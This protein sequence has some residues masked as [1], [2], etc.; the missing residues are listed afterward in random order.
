VHS[1]SV[2][3]KKKWAAG[4]V[5][6]GPFVSL[7]AP[8][9]VEIF[10]HAGFDLVVV[11]FE[12]GPINIE[13][14]ENMIRAANA[15]GIAA[16]IRV[17]S[18]QPEQIAAA[19]DLGAD[20]VVVPH[21]TC[22]ADAAA[23][24]DAARFAP[25]GSRGVAPFGRS[26]S[27]SAAMNDGFYEE[28]NEAVIVNVLLEGPEA[29]ENLDPLLE[30]PGLEVISLAPF[31]LSQALGVTGQ[32]DHPLV[33]ETVAEACRKAQGHGKVICFFVAEPS[34]AGPWLELGVQ[35]LTATV[36]AHMIYTAARR[37]VVELHEQVSQFG[38]VP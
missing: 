3:L 21:I 24:V 23:A 34:A 9:L 31:D 25:A 1:G 8:G 22:E 16:A 20:A 5:A 36:D 12:H 38:G 26:A 7:P 11:D 27:Y 15:S 4:E 14:A 6:F 30:M 18:N 32:I 13:T 28:A 10:A 2:R 17:M 29:I 19:L 35:W 33:V 37:F